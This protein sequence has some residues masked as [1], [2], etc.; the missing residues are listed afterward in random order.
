LQ[1]N[2]MVACRGGKKTPAVRAGGI[3][4]GLRGSQVDL[5]AGK[6]GDRHE[7]GEKKAPTEGKR[8]RPKRRLNRPERSI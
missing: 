4:R 8:P 3:G 6:E 1:K 5:K 2:D 7:K